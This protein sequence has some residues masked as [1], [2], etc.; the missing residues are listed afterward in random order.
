M[1]SATAMATAYR[2]KDKHDT[3]TG[4]EDGYHE[5]KGCHRRRAS[6]AETA[7]EGDITTSGPAAKAGS[8]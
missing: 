4:A 5:S 1:T 7:M 8:P 3:T 6:T 2:K